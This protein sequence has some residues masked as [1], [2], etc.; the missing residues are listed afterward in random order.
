MK[1]KFCAENLVS[2]MKIKPAIGLA[3]VG[4]STVAFASGCGAEKERKRVSEAPPAER[5]EKNENV[6]LDGC[7]TLTEAICVIPVDD[8][9]CLAF[10]LV[11]VK[12]C[13]EKK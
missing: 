12:E 2:K 11:D 1:E 10:K 4:L 7:R 6:D 3:I 5:V 8:G 13:P 9:K